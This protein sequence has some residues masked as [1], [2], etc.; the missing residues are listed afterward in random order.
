MILKDWVM[1]PALV[2]TVSYFNVSTVMV[3]R[4]SGEVIKD[5]FRQDCIKKMQLDKRI[6]LRV[7]IGIK[8]K[9]IGR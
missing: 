2:N 8:N 6:R 9:I 1:D 7:F 3:T 4:A 5:S